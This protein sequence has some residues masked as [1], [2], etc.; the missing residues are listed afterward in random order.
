FWDAT[1]K[2]L[3]VAITSCDTEKL[4]DPTSFRVTNLLPGARYRLTVD[5]VSQG[6][7]QPADGTLK[8]DTRV[9]T[10]TITLQQVP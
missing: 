2:S 5:G 3:V 1:E 6:D 9:G 4:G 7:V 10:H 8:V